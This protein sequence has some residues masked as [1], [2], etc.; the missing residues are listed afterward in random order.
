[1]ENNQWRSPEAPYWLYQH[2]RSIF[3]LAGIIVGGGVCLA[4][5]Y[6]F[7]PPQ[8]KRLLG[9]L[10]MLFIGMLGLVTGNMVQA[11]YREADTDPLTRL[12]NRRRFNRRLTEELQLVREFEQYSVLALVDVDNFKHIN[13]TAGYNTGDQVLV[14]I[15]NI[16]RRNLGLHDSVMRWGGDEFVFIFHGS[17]A[18]EGR[19]VLER[20]REQIHD[21]PVIREVTISAGLIEIKKQMTP[22]Q[23]LNQA[24]C[25]LSK[26]KQIK[27]SI[28]IC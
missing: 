5:E 20:I 14:R 12:G 27:N 15:S 21:D 28:E 23:V 1:M 11:L 19:L 10:I 6:L 9:W 18:G 16:F 24:D 13:D 2:A 3:A 25:L 8:M 7:F 22:D 4:Q 26:A 17:S